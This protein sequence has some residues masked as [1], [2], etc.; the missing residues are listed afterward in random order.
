MRERA[1]RKY[2]TDWGQV[3]VV[4]DLGYLAMLLG[5][6]RENARKLCVSNAIPAFKVGDMWRVNKRELMKLCGEEETGDL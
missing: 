1:H 2:V 4:V 6:S 3:P 5:C